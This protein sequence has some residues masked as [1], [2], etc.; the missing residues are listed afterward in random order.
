MGA[1]VNTPP[2]HVDLQ[3]GPAS[4]SELATALGHTSVSGAMKNA[5]NDLMGAGFVEYTIPEKPNSRLQRYVAV[6]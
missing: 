5:L 6:K 2:S 1:G 4:R 3:K